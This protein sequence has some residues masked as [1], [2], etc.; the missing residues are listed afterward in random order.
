MS[1]PHKFQTCLPSQNLILFQPDLC[2]K[3]GM[4][5]IVEKNYV[6]E[7]EEYY[8][9]AL[10]V[11]SDFKIAGFGFQNQKITEILKIKYFY[12]LEKI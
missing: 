5:V 11:I 6:K 7:I 9:E 2:L 8:G 4:I 1:T 10:D 12:I 3:K